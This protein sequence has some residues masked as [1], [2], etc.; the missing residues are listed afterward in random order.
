MADICMK[1]AH[2]YA[3]DEVKKRIQ[4]AF[5][6]SSEKF[7]LTTMWDENTCHISGPVKGVVNITSQEIIIEIKLGL[8]MKLMRST[9]EEGLRSSIEKVLKR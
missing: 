3:P 6:K 8:A 1:F 5:E 9:I 4:N 2:H 7:M